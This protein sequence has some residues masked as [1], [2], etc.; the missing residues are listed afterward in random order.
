GDAGYRSPCLTLAPGS[1]APGFAA[2]ATATARSRHP[3]GVNVAFADGSVRFMRDSTSARL[4]RSLGSR[5]G[6]E[7]VPEKPAPRP[8][9]IL[10]IGNSYTEANDL[11]GMV[12]TTWQAAGLGPVDVQKYTIG[13]ATLQYHYD[14]SDARKQIASQKWDY[15]VLQEQSMR[16]IVAP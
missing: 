13:G 16:P 3:G 8:I 12:K 2:G 9:R 6:D 7:V 11:P 1:S 10:F 14:K 15:V 4:W 5:A